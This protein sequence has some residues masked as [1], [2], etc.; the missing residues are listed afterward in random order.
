MGDWEMMAEG[1]GLTK[2]EAV[3]MMAEGLANVMTMKR[4]WS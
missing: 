4:T 1:V 3:V 2:Y